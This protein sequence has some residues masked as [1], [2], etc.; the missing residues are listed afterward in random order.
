[1]QKKG[2]K[3]TVLLWTVYAIL[4]NVKSSIDPAMQSTIK[5]T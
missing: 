1:M 3:N 4:A 2:N 5:E